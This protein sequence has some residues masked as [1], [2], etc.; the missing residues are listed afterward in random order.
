MESY[1]LYTKILAFF[2]HC[3]HVYLHFLHVVIGYSVSLL[4]DILLYDNTTFYMP[5]V[6][7]MDIW[8]VSSL[9]LL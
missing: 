5:I 8:V 7:L 1:S 2:Q 9:G 4:D 6:L 3:I